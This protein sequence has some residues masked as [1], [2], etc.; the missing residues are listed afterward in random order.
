MSLRIVK[1]ALPLLVAVG[2]ALAWAAPASAQ[3]TAPS[4]PPAPAKKAD[5]KVDAKG[6]VTPAPKPAAAAPKPATGTPI[7][8]KPPAEPAAADDPEKEKRRAIYISVD[9]GFQR[10]DVGGITD[11]TGFDKT[12]ANGLM[13]GLGIGYRFKE[14]RIGGRFR[15]SSTTEY[16]LRSI[17]GEIGWG[18]PLRPISPVFMVHAGYVYDTGVERSVIASSLPQ[19]NVLTPDVD[20]NGVVIGGEISA[21]YWLTKFLRIGPFIGGDVLLLHRSTVSTPQ[22]LFPLSDATK[23][24]PLYSDSGS[25]TGYMLSIGLRG[26]GDIAF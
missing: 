4:T 1:G 17:M 24:N 25:A 20:L 13:V 18:L 15:E 7:E 21:P 2:L 19:T 10:V 11:N 9:I 12:A 26:S 5:P 14:F 3:G 6:A 16:S 23:N 22:S 8:T